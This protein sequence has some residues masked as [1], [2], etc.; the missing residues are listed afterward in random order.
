MRSVKRLFAVLLLCGF[1]GAALAA[2]T[3]KLDVEGLVCAFC[4]SAIEKK[5]K[6]RAEVQDVLVSLDGAS[7]PSG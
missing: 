4:G 6:T 2:S 3:I 7:S 1:S 5:L